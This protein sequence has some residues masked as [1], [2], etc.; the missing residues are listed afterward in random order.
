MYS[1]SVAMPSETPQ[2]DNKVYAVPE[3]SSVWRSLREH[4]AYKHLF[5]D[6]VAK[7][8]IAGALGGICVLRY[9]RRF[10]MTLTSLSAGIGL[11]Y[12]FK[13]AHVYI[14]HP[15]PHTLPRTLTVLNQ[16]QSRLV[17]TL[18]RWKQPPD[19]ATVPEHHPAQ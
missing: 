10:T 11:G 18:R 17:T 19:A 3:S 9:S 4:G 5:V 7:G 2:Q 6:I 1:F 15:D 8:L 13:E 12:G 16:V 14:N